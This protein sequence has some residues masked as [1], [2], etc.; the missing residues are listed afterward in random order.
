MSYYAY[1][2]AMCVVMMCVV[3]MCV[4]MM[5]VVMMCVVMMCVVMMCVVM[6]C[7][8]M[9]CVVM[10]CV[11]M[12]CVVLMSVNET[13]ANSVAGQSDE[14]SRWGGGWQTI[15]QTQH[16]LAPAGRTLPPETA[17]QGLLCYLFL[18]FVLFQTKWTVS[19]CLLHAH[20]YF[21]IMA[22]VCCFSFFKK[23]LKHL[24]PFCLFCILGLI[25]ESVV[26][27]TTQIKITISTII[28]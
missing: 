28:I 6:M 19:F 21:N 20:L 25:W 26:K 5:C 7:V 13:D 24:I 15:A 12:M 8:V 9:M 22:K 11:V 14:V 1:P 17:W 18:S 10:M 4:V 2:R 16:D 23:K 27:E 3:M